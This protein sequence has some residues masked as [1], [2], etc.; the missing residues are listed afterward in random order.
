M[1]LAHPKPTRKP[2]KRSVAS[3]KSHY[4]RVAAMP[5]CVSGK[6][7][8]VLHHVPV[9]S[10]K[11]G[12]Q[13]RK[14]GAARAAVIPLTREEHEHLHEL[15]GERQFERALGLPA[16]YLVSRACWLLSETVTGE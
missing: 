13:V 15:G 9:T 2:R 6:S 3:L 8:V 1:T 4:D 16:N 5:S 10:P 11:S 7:P 12:Q 14:R